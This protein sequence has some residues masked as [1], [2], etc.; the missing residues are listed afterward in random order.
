MILPDNKF[1]DPY[2][3]LEPLEGGG[4]VIVQ[5][6]CHCISWEKATTIKMQLSKI[7]FFSCAFGRQSNF[8]VGP[9]LTL[10]SN[11][12]PNPLLT[13]P[14]KNYIFIVI[15]ACLTSAS[16][17]SA[18]LGVPKPGCFKPG[19]LQ[20]LRGSALLRPFALICALL[21]TCICALSRS[22]A[23]LR[24]RSFALFCAHLRV[25]AS[26]RVW[27][28]RV[29]ELQSLNWILCPEFYLVLRV[30]RSAL[31]AHDLAWRAIVSLANRERITGDLRR[32]IWDCSLQS[33]S[34][35]FQPFVQD[36]SEHGLQITV[37]ECS[38][39]N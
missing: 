38:G 36:F 23:D 27:N 10:F 12:L 14:L 6:Y 16:C 24:L 13:R 11:P 35:H 25:S 7:L 8:K 17:R 4:G 19:G 33:D 9:L 30:C 5:N 32:V 37:C 2:G 18:L 29:W 26:D 22:F 28:D 1:T 21:R 20:F 39:A 15:S 3:P 31:I 34:G